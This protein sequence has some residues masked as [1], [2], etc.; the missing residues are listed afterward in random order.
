[1]SHH[2]TAAVVSNDQIFTENI[3]AHTVNGTTYSG[4]RARTTG[5]PQNHWFGPCG[6][7][8][9]AGIGTAEAIQ[10]VWSH[11]RE[12]VTDIGPIKTD[13]TLPNPN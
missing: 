2:L 3:L 7:P 9:G 10:L 5:A 1:M 8:R 4:I 12:I 6:D 13:W 11:H